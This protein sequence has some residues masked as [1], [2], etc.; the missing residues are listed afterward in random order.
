MASPRRAHRPVRRIRPRERDDRA[1]PR[2]R[3]S[4]M[5]SGRRE[6]CSPS[7]PRSHNE[8]EC[9]LVRYLR[10]NNP[11]AIARL[12]ARAHGGATG[13]YRQSPKPGPGS[14]DRCTARRGRCGPRST[15]RSRVRRRFS[16]SDERSGCYSPTFLLLMAARGVEGRSLDAPQQ[17]RSHNE[18]IRRSTRS[19][20]DLN[21]SLH[22]TVRWA[23]S[24]SFRCT[25]STV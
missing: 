18:A 10:H 22:K 11:P 20:R 16:A 25:Q 23:W 15:A 21:G 6:V 17:P 4:L 8:V 13:R 1:I 24:L 9:P 7:Q 19:S 12:A 14:W 3:S 5:R 2:N